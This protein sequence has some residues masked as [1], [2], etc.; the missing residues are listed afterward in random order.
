MARLRPAELIVL[1][2]LQATFAFALTSKTVMPTNI[3]MY[4]K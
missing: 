1:N 2:H 4:E 3:N